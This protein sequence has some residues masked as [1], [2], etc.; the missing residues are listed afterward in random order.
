MPDPE[1]YEEMSR[2]LMR[3]FPG[4]RCWFG[5]ATGVWWAVPP[6]GHRCRRLLEAGTAERLAVLIHQAQGR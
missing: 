5:V 1:P 2:Q 4:W 3:A 6:P